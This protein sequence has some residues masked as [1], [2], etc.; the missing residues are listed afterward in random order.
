MKILNIV[1]KKKKIKKYINYNFKIV[2]FYIP[3][4]NWLIE[5]NVLIITV[6][7]KPT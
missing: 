3:A 1:C 7:N 5:Y 4:V 6:S 2:S